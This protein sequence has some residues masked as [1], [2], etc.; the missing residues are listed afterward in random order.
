M[1]ALDWF[2][3]A[4]LLLSM[5]LGA[6]RG[7]VFELISLAGWLAALALAWLF[8]GEVAQVLPMRGA[9]ESLRHVLA[10]LLVFVGTVMASALLAVVFKKLLSTVGLR[11][12]DRALGAL[13]GLSRGLLLLLLLA[14]LVSMTALKDAELWQQSQGARLALLALAHL[15]PVLPPDLAPY[16]PG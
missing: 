8:A 10:F 2:L 1:P 3:A 11:P 15:K 5:L 12:A 16:L 7:L 4:V 14:A 6:W 9:S 13:F